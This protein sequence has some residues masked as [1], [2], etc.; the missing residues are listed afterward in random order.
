MPTPTPSSQTIYR[1]LQSEKKSRGVAQGPR[2]KNFASMELEALSIALLNPVLF[3]QAE[4]KYNVLNE[5]EVRID[6]KLYNVTEILKHKPDFEHIMFTED[7]INQYASFV[8]T[9]AE[10]KP[11]FRG[12][13]LPPKG[14]ALGPDHL[15]PED[16]K[17]EDPQG[18]HNHL[19]YGEKL[20]I[21]TYT[22]NAFT[23]IQNFLRNNGVD[24]A[25]QR[26][27]PEQLKVK[28]S[29]LL[30]CSCMASHGL[31]DD[32][33]RPAPIEKAYELTYMSNT[34]RV[35]DQKIELSVNTSR[36]G[37]DFR[38]IDDKGIMREGLLLWSEFLPE[39]A[40]RD[41]NGI[42]LNQDVLLPRVI[43]LI[44][45]QGYTLKKD[46]FK[47]ALIR[48]ENLPPTSDIMVQRE[49][50]MKEER[51][52]EIQGF[53]STSLPEVEFKGVKNVKIFYSTKAHGKDVKELSQFPSEAEILFMPGVELQ[54][55]A[56]RKSGER[57][58]ILATPVRSVENADKNL[59][60][61][62]DE[63]KLTRQ[64]HVIVE[65]LKRLSNKRINELLNSMNITSDS[66][67]VPSADLEQLKQNLLILKKVP[68]AQK[69]DLL[70]RLDFTIAEIK[71][72][73]QANQIH[74]Q[75]SDVRQID[76]VL[77]HE[78]ERLQRVYH[79]EKT[80]MTPQ[81]EV[82]IQRIQKIQEFRDQ[83]RM[84]PEMSSK[85]LEK[86][87]KDL[88][89]HMK[90]TRKH[91]GR[92]ITRAGMFVSSK[93]EVHKAVVILYKHNPGLKEPN[94]LEKLFKK[95]H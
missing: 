58:N 85:E 27:S 39:I 22:G 62:S 74:A 90:S 46:D 91:F 31:R 59:Y 37:Y 94:I 21:T 86:G 5:L 13:T 87:L 15:T 43:D 17:R 81:R 25:L 48:M 10:A 18:K 65:M 33:A 12:K 36:Q 44:A 70:E 54:Y 4:F 7:E 52:T 61:Y 29:E 66:L 19:L 68:E 63:T 56:M 3:A 40:P 64:T 28:A 35:P 67:L 89:A 34:P 51:I 57:M 16:Y 26:L 75:R 72:Y 32:P 84:H 77:K 93:S 76:S 73:E 50:D 9:T 60:K 69:T 92:H 14:V 30:L 24:P 82:A 38:V 2:A 47:P 6:G 83:L 1:E 88:E 79:T 45:M 53:M 23:A 49:K 42:M 55:Q 71:K 41:M 11:M 80:K 20:A 8:H 95:K 78:I